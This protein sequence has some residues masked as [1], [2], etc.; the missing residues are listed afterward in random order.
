MSH[1]LH[2]DGAELSRYHIQDNHSVRQPGSCRSSMSAMRNESKTQ[3]KNGSEP[4]DASGPMF[5]YE[6][7][8]CFDNNSAILPS[9]FANASCLGVRP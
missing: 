1:V 4:G 3:V 9:P 7:L 2:R 6:L 5:C 8:P